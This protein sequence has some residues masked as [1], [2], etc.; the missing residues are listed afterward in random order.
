[1]KKVRN[2]QKIQL[3]MKRILNQVQDDC[4]LD[5][6]ELFQQVVYILH[7]PSEFGFHLKKAGLKVAA[8]DERAP[9]GRLL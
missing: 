5:H 6:A 9:A 4:A 7:G 3:P 2:L 1:M 8:L